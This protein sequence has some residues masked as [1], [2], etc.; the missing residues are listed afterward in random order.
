M[1]ILGIDPGTEQS[2][3][4]VLDTKTMDILNKG[5]YDNDEIFNRVFA[6]PYPETK[7]IGIVAIEMVASYGMPV[8]QTTF[9][10]VFWIGRFYEMF[11]NHTDA[12]IER[13]FKKSDINPTICFNAGA[14]DANIRQALIDMYPATGGGK[15]PQ[16]G[17]KAK[18][19]PLYG[20]SKD[21]WA[22]L[23]VA[24]TAGVANNYI[25]RENL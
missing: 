7:H 3:F 12:D 9:E 15:T 21:I 20:V 11:L 23:A 2:A 8:G 5:I 19:G 22:A 14:K 24:V 6:I 4:V 13:Y 10:T 1:L 17:T 25:Q 18:P 16:V